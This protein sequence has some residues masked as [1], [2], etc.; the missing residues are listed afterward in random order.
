MRTKNLSGI[1]LPGLILLVSISA[2]AQNEKD[3]DKQPKP[4]EKVGAGPAK[5]QRP[6]GFLND[7][8]GIFSESDREE[9]ESVLRQLRDR[10]EIELAIAIIDTTDG[11]D[12]FSYSLEMARE[13]KIG[14][15]NGGALLVVAI[16]DRNWYIQIDSRLQK[17]LANEEVRNIGEVM[18]PD[19]TE[20]KY[21]DGIKKCVEKMISVLAA[22]QH[23]EP[24][25][26]KAEVKK[27]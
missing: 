21:P 15:K 14:A 11:K 13:R 24:I 4:P 16:K 20:G 5:L 17:N 7:L 26:F 9:T 1:F 19:F 3:A 8:S 27:Q 23:F 25:K 12:I 10:A 2:F 18:I 6:T 22:K